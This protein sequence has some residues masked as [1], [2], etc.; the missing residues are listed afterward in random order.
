MKKKLIPK[1]DCKIDWNSWSGVR[2]P[3]YK[4]GKR[5]TKSVFARI[6]PNEWMVTMNKKKH[7]F[8]RKGDKLINAKY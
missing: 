6:G 7:R 8:I 1:S 4:N 3:D 5:I 2:V